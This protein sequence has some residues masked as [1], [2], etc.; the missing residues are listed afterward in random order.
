MRVICIDESCQPIIGEDTPHVVKG[1]IYT[2][3]D[4]R[5][6]RE[7]IVLGFRVIAGTYYLLAECGSCGYHESMFIKVNDNQIDETE[8]VRNYDKQPQ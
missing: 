2:V 7:K 1:N 3:I 4:S 5:Y 8:L 6:S